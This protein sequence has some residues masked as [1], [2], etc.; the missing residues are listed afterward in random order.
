M[1]KNIVDYLNNPKNTGTVV[2]AIILA[3]LFAFNIV[4]LQITLTFGNGGF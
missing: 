3:L 2:A 1:F 4:N